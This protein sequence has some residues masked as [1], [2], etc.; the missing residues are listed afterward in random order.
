MASS[1]PSSLCRGATTLLC[2]SVAYLCLIPSTRG[3]AS[4]EEL[5][6][7]RTEL[8]KHLDRDVLRFWTSPILNKEEYLGFLPLLDNQFDYGG[9]TTRNVTARG[10]WSTADTLRTTRGHPRHGRSSARCSELIF[11]ACLGSRD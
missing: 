7:L 5:T 9:E 8:V 4:A 6:G 2:A 3:E 10:M 11:T 1:I